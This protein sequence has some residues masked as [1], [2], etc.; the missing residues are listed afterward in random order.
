MST[1]RILTLSAALVVF[2]SAAAAQTL[3]TNDERRP[4]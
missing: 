3:V 1:P 4:A 2:A